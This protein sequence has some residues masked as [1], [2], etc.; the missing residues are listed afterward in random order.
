MTSQHLA[1]AYEN[2]DINANAYMAWL[3]CTQLFS[4]TQLA[5]SLLLPASLFLHN[6]FIHM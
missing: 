1:V 6:D 5:Q 4:V 2:S 3:M